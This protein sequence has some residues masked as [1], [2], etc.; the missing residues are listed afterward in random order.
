M[1]SQRFLAVLMLLSSALVG[2]GNQAYSV[3]Y[4]S[5]EGTGRWVFNI[6]GD[7]YTA[8]DEFGKRLALDSIMVNTQSKRLTVI[9]A[10]NGLDKTVPRLRMRDV[11]KECWTMAGLQP[12]DIKEIMGYRNENKD[13]Q[14]ALTQCRQDMNM[15]PRDSFDLSSTDTDPAKK[16]CWNRLAATAF[17]NAISGSISEFGLNKQLTQIK[18]SDGGPWDN[19]FYELS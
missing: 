11:V 2:M 9:R 12:S 7:G 19:L 4:E 16:T 18:V 17:G 15:Q 5:D 10:M 14:A 8:T 3:D 1:I 6:Y 13:V